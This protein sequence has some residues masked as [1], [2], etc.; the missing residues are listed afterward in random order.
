MP[1][2]PAVNPI[3]TVGDNVTVVSITTVPSTATVIRTADPLPDG[4]VTTRTRCVAP[5]NF[6][7]AVLVATYVKLSV[8]PEY[9]VATPTKLFD[10]SALPQFCHVSNATATPLI[11][12]KPK[13]PP[14]A[15]N[16][17]APADGFA[18]VNVNPSAPPAAP[19][20]ASK[21]R[22]KPDDDTAVGQNALPRCDADAGVNCN[23]PPVIDAFP[24]NVHPPLSGA[25]T[26]P[27]GGGGTTA[28]AVPDNATVELPPSETNTNEPDTA[29]TTVGANPTVT[30]F[31]APGANVDPTAGNPDADNGDTG[32]VTA[33]NV[34]TPEPVF[35][36]TTD[37]DPD[38]PLSLIHI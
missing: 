10:T 22:S 9:P 32:P 25:G 16:A 13:P 24:F 7:T 5:P 20:S 11:P 35:D 2:V 37:F 33:E 34:N 18:N 28:V 36:T 14:N 19:I 12:A 6:G 31:D 38:D 29:P 21:L 8:D 17:V 1:P 4:A 27:A 30:V 3:N 23:A 15:P 26:V